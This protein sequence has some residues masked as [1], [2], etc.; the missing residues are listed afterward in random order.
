MLKTFLIGINYYGLTVFKISWSRVK[1]Q[2]VTKTTQILSAF[3]S[4]LGRDIAFCDLKKHFFTGILLE[5]LTT[6]NFDSGTKV[7]HL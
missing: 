5:S 1:A 3:L 7:D 6:F 2:F 4:F